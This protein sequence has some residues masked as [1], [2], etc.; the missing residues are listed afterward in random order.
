[1]PDNKLACIAL[2]DSYYLGVLSSKAHTAWALA[3]GGKLG[4]GND[5]VYVKT[6]CFDPFPFPT[7]TEVYKPRVRDLGESLDAH[8]KRQQALHPDLT[9]TGMYNVL[10]KLR[11]GTGRN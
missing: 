5:P 4:V 1:M 10:E 3:A 9:L 8:R 2:Q 6:K 7:C 11:S